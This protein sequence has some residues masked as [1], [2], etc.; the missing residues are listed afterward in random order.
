MAE[1]NIT[2]DKVNG[3]VI[4]ADHVNELKSALVTTLSGRDASGTMTAG[5]QL[6][7]ATYPWGLAYIDSLIS[8]GSLIDFSSLATESNKIKSGQTRSTSDQADFIRALGT[9]PAADIQGGT[10][11]LSL[12]INGSAATVNAT[13]N[14]TSLTTASSGAA[15]QCNINEI[16]WTGQEF[17]KYAGE[18]DIINID[19]VGANIAAKVGQVVC[20]R[21]GTEYFLAF[22][23]SNTELSNCKRGYFFNSSGLPVVRTVLNNNDTLDLMSLGYVFIED[24]GATVEVSYL[25][26]VYSFNEPIGAATGQYWFDLQ[27]SQWRRYDGANFIV[28]NRILTGLVVID[29]TNCVASR[30]LDFDLDY[31]DLNSIIFNEFD[32]TIITSQRVDNSISVNANKFDIKNKISFNITTDKVVGVSE[33]A[34]TTYYCYLTQEGQKFIDTER[35]Y[36]IDPFKKGN[37]HPY[38]SWRC[39]LSFYNDSSSN[40]SRITNIDE[41]FGVGLSTIT[42]YG[43]SLLPQQITIENSGTDL[44]HDILFNAG[45]FNF[46]DGSGQAVLSSNLIKQIDAAWVAGNNQGGLFSGTVTQFLTYH[47]F[48]ISNDDGSLVDAGFS[49]DINATDI[50]TGYTKKRRIASL[51]IDINSNIRRG[52]YIFN[53]DGSYNFIYKFSIL[54]I[55]GAGNFPLTLTNLSIATPSGI[56][57]SPSFDCLIRSTGSDGI[58]IADFDTETEFRIASCANSQN[59]GSLSSGALFTNLTSQVKYRNSGNDA[60]VDFNFDINVCGW[61]D[62]N[63]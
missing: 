35:P 14:L 32:D 6:G 44:N 42:N 16:D 8:N 21:A 1:T 4:Q 61:F 63:L 58:A 34:D 57:T 41:V 45:N 11:P 36:Q 17:T 33:T 29:P 18:Q 26:P 46:D 25:N 49:N 28:I 48:V 59:T 55:G 12:V 20:L 27:S 13:I 23:K 2:A 60:F 52:T 56:K 39:L 50:P 22:V 54:A 15:S 38:N 19:A 5:Q 3:Q 24:D 53:R 31:S 40:I 10:T 30:S 7:S 37:Y 47:L 62:N 43:K 51:T 9:S